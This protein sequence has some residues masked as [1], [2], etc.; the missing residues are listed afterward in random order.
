ML[1]KQLHLIVLCHPFLDGASN[2]RVGP[3]ICQG[4]YSYTHRVNLYNCARVCRGVSSMFS[5]KDGGSYSNVEGHCYC[6]LK[7]KPDGTCTQS[8]SSHETLWRYRTPGK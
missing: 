6:H 3:Y 2:Y 5:W 1:E 8:A 4:G 7:A